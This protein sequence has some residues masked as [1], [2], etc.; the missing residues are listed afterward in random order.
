VCAEKIQRVVADDQY[1]IN[2]MRPSD[3]MRNVLAKLFGPPSLITINSRY[4]T[5]E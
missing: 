3:Q 4:F 5:C 2:T 1:E